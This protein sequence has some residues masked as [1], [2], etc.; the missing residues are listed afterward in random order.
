MGKIIDLD[1]LRP[2]PQMVKLAGREIDVSFIPC[3]ITF[4]LDSVLRELFGLDQEKVKTDESEQKK[5]IG[6]T[7]QLCATF[8]KVKYPDMDSDW[9]M[10]NT[11]PAQ[12][13]AFGEAIQNTL[14]KIYSEIGAHAKN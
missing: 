14:T 6:L 3:G 11:S 7:A 5:A 13:K 10:D 1:I 9:F 4:E 8:C 2:E 12:M